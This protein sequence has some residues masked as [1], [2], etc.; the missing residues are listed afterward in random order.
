MILQTKNYIYTIS[1]NCWES[2]TAYLFSLSLLLITEMVKCH[3]CTEKSAFMQELMFQ[4]IFQAL[5]K[6]IHQ[7][8]R[9]VIVF[10]RGLELGPTFTL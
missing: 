3:I 2:P 6:L 10:H 7:C 9:H 5:R 1:F 8:P 4:P